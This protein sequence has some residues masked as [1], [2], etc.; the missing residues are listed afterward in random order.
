[1]AIE[2]IQATDTL[3]VGREK[4]N[5]FAIDPAL[6]AEENSQRALNIASFASDES[7]D[8]KAKA[9]NVQK[10]LDVL[11]V[12]GDSSVEAA[13]ARISEDGK[14][15]DSLKERLDNHNNSF[16]IDLSTEF[17]GGAN[18]NI[19]ESEIKEIINKIDKNKFN[20][21]L[22]TDYHADK[23]PNPRY[24]NAELAYSHF[25]NTLSFDGAVDTIIVNGDNID[26][27]YESLDRIKSETKALASN[28]LDRQSKSDIFI[29]LG[30]HDDGSGRGNANNCALD[31]FITKD[32]YQNYFRTA[33]LVNDEVRE[34][35]N[36]LYYYKDYQNKKI[37]LIGLYTED[38]NEKLTNDAGY[39][40]YTRWLT[41]TVGQQQLDWLANVALQNVPEDFSVVVVGHCPLYYNWTDNGAKQINHQF[42]KGVLKA[43]KEGGTYSETSSEADFPLV[44][45]YDFTTQGARNL[46]GFFAGHTHRE[47]ID[48][49]DGV[50][51]IHCL[52]SIDNADSTNANTI[53]EDAQTIV[54]VDIDTK[55]VKLYGLGRATDRT[56]EY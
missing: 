18:R 38:I 30:N 47:Q 14:E 43:F 32:E 34:N 22:G 42:Q 2:K 3:N 27:M 7:I 46:V 17:D 8:A 15:Y 53:N 45:N 54:E 23:R 52:H 1:M 55:K 13:Q 48:N 29:H 41:H 33:E 31:G 16:L 51:I 24:V 21:V 50:N 26:A 4:I 20:F 36:S 39:L 25:A 49:W 5:K 10:Q 11:V 44:A 40:K 56:F 9:E 19:F 35:G 28:F 37:R 6:R 12:E